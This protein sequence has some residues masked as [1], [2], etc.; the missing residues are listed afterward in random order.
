VVRY[1]I[2]HWSQFTARAKSEEGAYGMPDRPTV[3]FLQKFIRVAVNLYLEVTGLEIRNSTVRPREKLLAPIETLKERKQS[4]ASGPSPVPEP[5]FRDIPYN[6]PGFIWDPNDWHERGAS[7]I[8]SDFT[9][10]AKHRL[11]P[12]NAEYTAITGKLPPAACRYPFNLEEYFSYF[13]PPGW[14]DD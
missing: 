10:Y 14:D 13:Y 2:K 1:A 8:E 6:P 12:Y 5:T 3:D 7:R 4:Q 9:G 11:E